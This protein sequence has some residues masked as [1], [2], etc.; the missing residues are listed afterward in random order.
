MKLAF[1][2]R[3]EILA[4][5]DLRASRDGIHQNTLKDWKYKM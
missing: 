3:K 4:I 1:T 2:E 5:K